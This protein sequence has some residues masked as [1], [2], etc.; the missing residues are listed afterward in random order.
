M[1]EDNY[2]LETDGTVTFDIGD[3]STRRLKRPSLGQYRKLM[4]LLDT[5]RRDANKRQQERTERGDATQAP[6]AGESVD[7]MVTWLDG[8]FNELSDSPLPRMNDSVDI[9]KL[10]VW[11]VSTELV[12][13]LIGHWQSTPSHRGG[14]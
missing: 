4:E 14:R 7:D 12:T 2:T 11:F 6:G 5:L 3:G 13:D 1:P 9:D 8:V 10:P